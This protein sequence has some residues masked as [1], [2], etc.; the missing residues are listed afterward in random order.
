[1]LG[2]RYEASIFRTR[3]EQPLPKQMHL[4]LCMF[5]VLCVQIQSVLTDR[6]AMLIRP[7]HV[8]LWKLDSYRRFYR[9]TL[10]W[11]DG[12]TLLRASPSC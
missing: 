3:V 8:M 12:C 5:C 11:L 9:E 4:A 6:V 1:M 2:S 10:R 7:A